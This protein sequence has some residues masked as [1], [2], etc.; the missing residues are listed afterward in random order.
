MKRVRHQKAEHQHFLLLANARS[1]SFAEKTVGKLVTA[2]RARD[3]RYTTVEPRAAHELI[4][5]GKVVITEASQNPGTPIGRRGKITSVIAC[6]G[7]GT[8]NLAARLAL[9]HDLPLGVLPLG[10]F[11]NIARSLYGKPT[12][13]QAITKILAG[14]YRPFDVGTAGDQPFLGSLG[15]GFVPELAVQLLGR[16]TPLLGIGWSQLAAK[17]AASIPVEPLVVKLDAHRLE[18][19]PLML[20]VHLLPYAAGLPFS[21]G[22]IADDGLAEVI[23]DQGRQMGEFSAYLRGVYRGKYLYSG[24]FTQYRARQINLQPVKGRTLYLDGEL[25]PIPSTALAIEIGSRQVRI[26]C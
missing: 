11:N 5:E 13:D 10:R 15:I 25:V 7:D 12:P 18:I 26:Y 19:S 6:G 23:M 4:P 2:I 17:V 22:S 14:S 1:G 3:W 24:A 21:P 16:R 9:E 8:V 20:H